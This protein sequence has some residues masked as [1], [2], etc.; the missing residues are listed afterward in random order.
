MAGFNAKWIVVSS[1]MYANASPFA[2]V[3][4][5]ILAISKADV[6][7][8]GVGAFTAFA[9]TTGADAQAPAA[10]YDFA[11]PM[12]YLLDEWDGASRQVRLSTISGAVGA[13]VYTPGIAFPTYPGGAWAVTATASPSGFAPQLGSPNRIDT[14]D[15]RMQNLV[16]RNGALW[17]AHTVFLPATAPTRTAVQ[18]WQLRTGGAVLQSGRIDDLSGDLYFAYPSIAVSRA[19]DV[20]IGYSRFGAGQYA[21][22]N[23]AFRAAADP[24]NTMRDDTVF[25]AGLAPYY[26]VFGGTRNRWGDYSATAVDPAGDSDLW[27]IQEYAAAPVAGVDRWGTWW[28]R[29]VPP[30]PAIAVSPSSV[31]FGTQGIGTTSAPRTVTVTDTGTAPLAIGTVT[32]SGP[33]AGVF[34]KTADSC[35]GATLAPSASCAIDVTFAPDRTGGRAATLTIPSNAPGG[36]ASVALSGTGVDVTAPATVITAHP[37]DPTNL[38]DAVFAFSISDPDDPPSALTAECRLDAGAFAACVSPKTYAGLPPGTHTFAVHA[39]DAAGNVGAEATFTWRVDLTAPTVTITSHPADPTTATAATIGFTVTDPDDASP[40]TACSLDGAP[41]S[42]CSSPATYDNLPNGTHTVVIRATDAAGNAGRASFTWRVDLTPPVLQLTS[43]PP[44]R[45]NEVSATFAF[46]ASDPDDEALQI[47]CRLDGAPFSPC[48]SRVTYSGLVPGPHSFAVRA[49][50]AAGNETTATYAWVV[51]T[52]RPTVVIDSHPPALAGFNSTFTF[53]A[54][55]PDDA[56]STITFECK[57]DADAFDACASPAS[58]DGLPSGTHTFTVVARDLAGNASAP[59]SYTW[60]VDADPPRSIFSA[61]GTVLVEIEGVR[62]D[63]LGGTTTDNLSGVDVVEVTFTSAIGSAA[64]VTPALSCADPSRHSCAWTVRPP[65][66]PGPYTVEARGTDA[67]GN[68][69][70]RGTR[71]TIFVI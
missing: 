32:V 43:T 8:G 36:P 69:E 19:D 48:A 13:E 51:D 41:F 60:T 61:P 27:T 42:A 54:T 1:N 45:T 66:F 30:V 4:S 40:A 25:K 23:Y 44:A 38:T 53:S 35:S 14:G 65:Q 21:S 59:A 37:A 56:P 70:P 5:R 52:T 63:E 67:V 18:W 58:Y 71:V 2:F 62:T 12:L 17:A 28:G 26:K 39:R 31:A 68:V 34:S 6:Y 20:L 3:D 15:S 46:A 57:L 29:L 47:D 10:T 49:T 50:D 24:A 64:R 7:A 16:Y 55:D 11:Q 22:A 33:D 9:D